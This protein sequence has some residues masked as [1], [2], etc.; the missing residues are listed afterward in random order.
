MLLCKGAGVWHTVTP[1]SQRIVCLVCELAGAAARS[2]AGQVCCGPAGVRA[3]CTPRAGALLPAETSV[4]V[5]QTMYV[6]PCVHILHEILKMGTG[7]GSGVMLRAPEI[8]RYLRHNI[9]KLQLDDCGS[10]SRH[11]GVCKHRDS[12]LPH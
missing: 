10:Q 3:G 2:A 4:A 5:L 12:S 6:G 8:N 9:L 11:E 7:T 1:Q